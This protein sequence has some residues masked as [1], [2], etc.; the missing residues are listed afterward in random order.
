MGYVDLNKLQFKITQTNKKTTTSKLEQSFQC[1]HTEWT[2]VTSN[3]RYQHSIVMY[4]WCIS[5]NFDHVRFHITFLFVA[6]CRND[7]LASVAISQ[8]FIVTITSSSV[9]ELA[10]TS[11]V[12]VRHYRFTVHAVARKCNC[13]QALCSHSHP[14]T[15]FSF[16]SSFVRPFVRSLLRCSFPSFLSFCLLVFTLPQTYRM[17]WTE[18]LCCGLKFNSRHRTHSKTFVFSWFLH[19]FLR[20][21]GFLC[22]CVAMRYFVWYLSCSL[23]PFA[24]CTWLNSLLAR[25]FSLLFSVRCIL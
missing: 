24:I 3:F 21:Q 1:H 18:F 17:R 5:R 19:Y 4:P 13:S 2:L 12:I 20:T 7:K 25:F 14:T 9:S 8:L 15:S 16:L 22:C 10:V 11:T 6:F 23:L